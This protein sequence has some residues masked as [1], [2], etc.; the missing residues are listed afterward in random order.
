M[1][2]LL[3]NGSSWMMV[4][5]LALLALTIA[6]VWASLKP[7]AGAT[8]AGSDKLAHGFAYM[9]LTL[10]G[11]CNFMTFRN[12]VLF[13]VFALLLGATMEFCQSFIPGRD[14]SG[15]DMLANSAGVMLAIL[16]Y[17][18]IGWWRRRMRLAIAIHEEKGQQ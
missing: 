14:M 5:R 7:N 6:V 3:W 12:K 10:V 16:M 15:A 1:K 18:P 4:L 13:I 2:R 17:L 11:L 8:I 9:S